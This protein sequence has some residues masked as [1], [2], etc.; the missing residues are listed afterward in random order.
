MSLALG[1]GADFG[2]AT[3]RSRLPTDNLE[4]L[5]N[6]PGMNSSTDKNGPPAKHCRRNGTSDCPLPKTSY[7]RHPLRDNDLFLSRRGAMRSG[8]I[9]GFALTCVKIRGQY[10]GALQSMLH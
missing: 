1:V 9:Q 3:S 7:L 5:P 8:H 10:D 4:T 2:V 6:K